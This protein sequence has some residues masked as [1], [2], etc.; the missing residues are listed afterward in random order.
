MLEKGLYKRDMNI[1]IDGV[2]ERARKSSK[3]KMKPSFKNQQR[4]S[5]ASANWSNSKSFKPPSEA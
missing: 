5:K 1:D 3:I 4:T 2:T